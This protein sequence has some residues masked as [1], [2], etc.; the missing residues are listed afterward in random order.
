[1]S[2]PIEQAVIDALLSHLER[3]CEEL[4]QT[5]NQHIAHNAD[6]TKQRDWQAWNI[7]T[8]KIK[9]AQK[10]ICEL[11]IIIER[12]LLAITHRV[13]LIPVPQYDNLF[14][15]APTLT[16]D[17]LDTLREFWR[18][19]TRRVDQWAYCRNPLRP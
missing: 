16:A 1:M 3:E 17:Q 2:S 9:A 10:A 7:P 4:N 12:D 13:R 15:L 19:H 5:T 14:E 8:A 6:P 18:D 11:A